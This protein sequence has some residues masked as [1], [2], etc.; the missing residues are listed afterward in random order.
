MEMK[1]IPEWEME[2]IVVAHP[3]LL[4]I[5]TN[6]LD[7][8]ILGQQV[9]LPKCGGYIDVL[10]TSADGIVVIELKNELIDD[11]RVVTDQVAKYIRE[12]SDRPA[13]QDKI[14]SLLVSTVGFSSAVIDAAR[15]SSVALQVLPVSR[16][17]DASAHEK[18]N[19]D[20]VQSAGARLLQRRLKIASLTEARSLLSG[21]AAGCADTDVR[22]VT[23]FI[24]TGQHD[25]DG[26][27]RLALTLR[28][29]SRAAPIMAHSVFTEDR[30]ELTSE[31]DKWFWMFY[32]VLD[33]RAN[34][35]T[36]IKARRA[37]EE[38]HLF[39]PGQITQLIETTSY[40]AAANKLFD[41]LSTSGFPVVAD[42]IRRMLAMPGSILDASLY[43]KRF[44]YSIDKA[45]AFFVAETESTSKACLVMMKDMRT[46][47]YGVG[48][49][50]AAQIVRGLALKAGY[51]L[52]LTDKLHLERCSFN[53]FFAGPARLGLINNGKEYEPRLE[54]FARNYL[55]NN[56]G[57]ISHA[58]WL[59]RKR[60]CVRQRRCHECPVAGFCGF[61]RS[62]LLRLP[63]HKQKKQQLELFKTQRW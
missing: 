59:V 1:F 33:R 62:Q 39:S 12:L 25:N 31:E 5:A 4:E 41:I 13:I 18:S 56:Y 27:Q 6:S 26:L 35:R 40:E 30:G 20:V 54:A 19:S 61:F 29:I 49:R 8:K 7:L 47:I 28:A 58:L 46:H 44:D 37:L 16:L 55:D 36:F 2:E 34:A 45:V 11:E 17:L 51:D 21:D 10:A 48:P 15:D 43:L 60:F 9:Y 3:E 42:S 63:A 38:H 57:I 22:S 53:E 52:P 50:I 32:S 23:R 14:R 24:E